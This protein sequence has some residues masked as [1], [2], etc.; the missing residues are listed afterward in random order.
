MYSRP[1]VVDSP[2]DIDLAADRFEACINDAIQNSTLIKTKAVM[3]NLTLPSEILQLIKEKN[4]IR[5]T[6]QRFRLPQIKT[7][8][9]KLIQEIN[10]KIKAHRQEKWE[11][12]IA[13]IADN[14]HKYPKLLLKKH[15]PVPTILY[16][17]TAA[18]TDQEKCNAFSKSLAKKYVPFEIP[19]RELKINCSAFSK[20]LKTVPIP[21]GTIPTITPEAVIGKI[22]SLPNAKAPG[23]D[24]IHN[25]VLKNLPLEAVE[26]LT[27]I[28]N[29][30][31]ELSH[32][33][34][35][36]KH[37]RVALIPKP[38]K[39][40]SDPNNYRP[41]HL[42][43]SVS[44]LLESFM[45]G[46]LQ[47]HLDDNNVIPPYQHGFRR[48]LST[49]LQ[50]TRVVEK[51]RRNFNHKID[52]GMLS[53]DINQAFDKV[54]HKALLL[55][56]IKIGTPIYLTKLLQSYLLGR[57]FHVAINDVTSAPTP[58]LS[59]VPQGSILG[60][61]LFNI[62]LYDLPNPSDHRIFY[63]QY[64]DDIAIVCSSRDPKIIKHLLETNLKAI[65]SYLTRWAM[66]LN[67]KKSQ[68]TLFTVRHRPSPVS[69]VKHNSIKIPFQKSTNYL[70]VLLDRKLTFGPHTRK[71]V[72]KA[73]ARIRNLYPVFT[74]RS[75][76]PKS[77][78]MIYK[79][80]IRPIL[81]YASPCW[82]QMAPT[83]HQN[84]QKVQNTVLRIITSM[85]SY[86]TIADLHKLSGVEP[87]HSHI[88]KLNTT[89]HKK[90][91]H[92]TNTSLSDMKTNIL[93]STPKFLTPM[94]LFTK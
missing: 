83:H 25:V 39:S 77:N 43:N 45:Y 46:Y 79:S 21:S 12:F 40:R 64:A 63:A 56:L 53:L 71:S 59:G 31:F 48:E 6:F 33:P 92:N 60:P 29:K 36:W 74:S 52:T 38:N 10:L 55:K 62:F 4:K 76:T 23:P 42:L 93:P 58:A 8:L 54:H 28:F 2:E 78:T 51:V 80:Y 86:T 1:A 81:T 72:L 87:L 37:S 19:D 94:T 68:A 47:D 22:R 69:H 91:K 35:S 90:L 66:S 75:A 50:L 70:G 17:G 20:A 9:N 61:V 30:C 16:N 89:F 67:A 57:T 41:I 15:S 84:L 44:K 11:E 3:Y 34:T 85:P 88:G 5:K 14:P 32:F 24:R 26:H 27:L 65:D 82:S 49:S 18:Y 13:K 73:Q 7:R